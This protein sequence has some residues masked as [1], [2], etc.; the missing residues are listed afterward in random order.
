MLSSTVASGQTY[1]TYTWETILFHEKH[2]QMCFFKASV[3]VGNDLHGQTLIF[4][5][6]D[7]ILCLKFSLVLFWLY[8]ALRP[9]NQLKKKKKKEIMATTV[10]GLNI[11]S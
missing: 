2:S 4:L 10:F 5:V 3:F 6:R 11:S 8:H 7:R 1:L 9:Q